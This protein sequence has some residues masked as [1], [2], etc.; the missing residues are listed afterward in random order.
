MPVKTLIQ[1]QKYMDFCKFAKTKSLELRKYTIFLIYL[2]SMYILFW[3]S[4]HYVS[5]YHLL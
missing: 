3:K 1:F 2:F 5:I 4:E